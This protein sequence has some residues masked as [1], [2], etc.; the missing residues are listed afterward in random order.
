MATIRELVKEHIADLGNPPSITGIN[1]FR[2]RVIE[3]AEKPDV[4]KAI[5]FYQLNAFRNALISQGYYRSGE[6]AVCNEFCEDL[7]MLRY[8]AQKA[9]SQVK[10]LER[11]Y[12]RYG[13]RVN[14]ISG[15]MEFDLSSEEPVVREAK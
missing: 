11:R 13:K 12:V 10:Q 1:E 4:E 3:D 6:D 2:R 14:E 5:T 9:N 8:I 7:G 15:Q